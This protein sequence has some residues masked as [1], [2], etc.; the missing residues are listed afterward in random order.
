MSKAPD[1]MIQGFAEMLRAVA[2]DPATTEDDLRHAVRSAA[3]VMES[4]GELIEMLT[5]SFRR[6]SRRL[7][8]MAILFGLLAGYQVARFFAWL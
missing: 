8:V 4:Q 5:T 2:D 3:D 6:L 1:P 7:L